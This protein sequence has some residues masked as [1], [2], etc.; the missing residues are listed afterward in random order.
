MVSV[1]KPSEVQE[2]QGVEHDS[3][4][5]SS[6]AET[7]GTNAKRSEQ[8]INLEQLVKALQGDVSIKLALIQEAGILHLP[9]LPQG[10]TL[11]YDEQ[12]GLATLSG[13]VA[14]VRLALSDISFL[15]HSVRP[16]ILKIHVEITDDIQSSQVNLALSFQHESN[17]YVPLHANQSSGQVV[18]SLEMPNPI[19]E[20]EAPIE[21]SREYEI[22]PDTE[23]ML[24]NMTQ[25]S[26]SIIVQASLSGDDMTPQSVGQDMETLPV[27][28]VPAPAPQEIEPEPAIQI[29]QQESAPEVNEPLIIEDKPIISSGGGSA[30]PSLTISGLPAGGETFTEDMTLDLEDIFAEYSAAT[31]TVTLTLSDIAAGAL[32][33]NAVGGAVVA[34]D[35]LTGILTVAGDVDDVNDSLIDLQFIPTADYDKDFTIAIDL[36]DGDGETASDTI[37]MTAGTIDDGVTLDNP[38]ADQLAST[39]AAFSFT[40][41]ANTFGNPDT[42]DVITYSATQTDG[43]ALPAWLSFD[44]VTGE[45]SGTAAGGDIGTIS[46]RITADDGQGNTV[47]D[48]FDVVVSSSLMVTNATQNNTVTEEVVFDPA[49]ITVTTNESTTT[50]TLTLSAAAAGAFNVATS[51]AVTSTYNAG[52]GI[53]QA[54][55]AVADVNA[56]LAGLQFTPATD[57]DQNFT[58]AVSVDDGNNPLQA[59]T[60]TMNVTAVNDAPVLDSAETDKVTVATN[61]FNLDISGNFSDVDTGETLNYTATL[62]GG[63]ALPGWLTLNPTTGVFSG[64]PGVGDIAT[65]DIVVTVTDSGALTVTDQFIVDV[66]A[67]GLIIG[68]PNQDTITGTNGVNE[69]Y[70][71]GDDDTIYGKNGNDT[72]YGEDGNDW[73]DGGYHRDSIEGGTGNDTLLGSLVYSTTDQQDTLKGGDGDDYLDGGYHHDSLLGGAGDDTLF[74]GNNND[75]LRAGDGN[76]FLSGGLHTDYLYGETGTYNLMIAGGQR[77]VLYGGTGRDIFSY[78]DVSHSAGGARD[79]IYSFTQGVDKIDLSALGYTGIGDLTITQGGTTRITAADG[80]RIDVRSNIALN[81][82]DF[83]FSAAS[84]DIAAADQVIQSGNA[85]NLPLAANSFTSIDD[86]NLVYDIFAPNGDA[87]H[88]WINFDN[89]TGNLS[90]T[91]QSAQSGI[92]DVVLRATNASGVIAE[93]TFTITVA[94]NIITGTI[95]ADT[96]VGTASNDAIYGIGDNDS[97]TAGDG[98][99]I[100][101]TLAGNDTIDAGTGNDTIYSGDG[102]D[103]IIGGT[104]ADLIYAGAGDDTIVAGPDN[105]NNDRN[106][107]VYAGDGNDVIYGGRYHDTLYGENGDDLIYG[108]Y[109]NDRIYGGAGNDTLLGGFQNDYLYAGDGNDSLNGGEHNDR[110]YGG[111]GLNIHDGWSGTDYYYG[112]SGTDLY[113]FSALSHSTADR[114][115]NFQQG[116]DKIDVSALGFTG[117]GDLNITQ[118]GVTTI[119]DPNSTFKVNVYSNIALTAADFIFA[120]PAADGDIVDQAHIVNTLFNVTL[121][122]GHFTSID[123]GNL[124][125]N[126][127]LSNGS[128]L[129]AWLTFDQGTQTLSGTP[130]ANGFYDITIRGINGAGDVAED[131]FTLSIGENII[132][133]TAGTD[134]LVGTANADVIIALA[135]DD[136]ITGGAGADLIHGEAGNDTIKGENDRDTVYAGDGDDFIDGGFERDTVYGGDGNDTIYGSQTYSTSDREDYLYGEGGND[137]IDGGYHHDRIYGGSG[138]DTLFGN[139]NNDYLY[140]GDGTDILIGGSHND[141]LY[142]GAGF[143]LLDGGAHTDYYYSGAGT[144]IYIF[145]KLTDST[146]D[147][148]YNFQQG[149]DKIDLSKLGFTG[150]GDL[151][152][153]QGGTTTIVDPGSSFKINVMSNI[154]LVAND[155]IFSASAS[156]GDITLQSA[157][158][159]VAYNLA[160]GVGHFTS[161]DDGNLVYSATLANG[162]PI[163]AWLSVDSTTGTL[164]GTPTDS[165]TGVFDIVLR[166]TNGSAVVAEDTFEL[167]VASAVQDGT[168]GNDTLTGT[169]NDDALIG[170][171]GDDSLTGGAGDDIL[172]GENG[173][174]TLIGGDGEDTLNG[175]AG[176]DWLDGGNAKDTIHGGDGNDVIIG[177]LTNANTDRQ[178]KLYG[179]AGNDTID[180]GY[181][182]DTLYGGDGDDM[183]YGNRHNDSLYGGA[184]RDFIHGGNDVDRIYGQDGGDLIIGW[185][186]RDSIY[187]GDGDDIIM[188]TH[189]NYSAGGN[190]DRLYDFTQ[191]E[192]KIDV[193]MLGIDS[194]DHLTINTVGAVTSITEDKSNFRIDIESNIVLA[195]SDF[196]FS[197]DVGVADI[198]ADPFIAQTGVAFSQNLPVGAFA[199]IDDGNIRYFGFQHNGDA[200]PTWLHVDAATGEI[201]GTAPSAARVS[202]TIRAVNGSGDVAETTLGIGVSDGIVTGTGAGDTAVG[203][204]GVSDGFDGLAGND[205]YAGNSGNDA[206]SGGAGNDTLKGDNNDDFIDGGDGD[207]S[208]DGGFHRDLIFGGAGNDTLI[209]GSNTSNND[210]ED[211]IFGGDGND[212][213]HGG[214]Y[215]DALYGEAGSDTIIGGIHND[216]LWGGADADSL[217]G[218]QQNDVLYGESGDDTLI[219]GNNNDSLYG[220]AGNDTIDGSAH[221]DVLWG[222]TGND[223]FKFSALTHSGG[224]NIDRIMDFVR[225]SDDIDVSPL[226]F[227]GIGDL[228][229]TNN[230]TI[231]TVTNGAGFTF[232]LQGVYA[233]DATDFLF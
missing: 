103:S 107:T 182:H 116:T 191:G 141:R 176:D 33:T 7:G 140:A 213:I 136:S 94:D 199:S 4:P 151:T 68:T 138:D 162:N 229:I 9:E 110:T 101:T 224:G 27:E 44:T 221:R 20:E 98:N 201:S 82:N 26:E 95:A 102:D 13:E 209:G 137:Y 202:I 135:D 80:L 152:I 179:D 61:A 145:S 100:I 154:A 177:G 120:A 123:D 30:P 174:D 17:H 149:T 129:P 5:V 161:I 130:T 139:N 18:P 52:T 207:D 218:S 119:V 142:G 181:H 164:S 14:N 64:T 196:I 208:I 71:R 192:D 43:S 225:G 206:I 57:Y 127:T 124:F 108:E 39:G 159:G 171:D 112:G 212:Y 163:P 67:G 144:D 193:S 70:G 104:Q 158:V 77:D 73:I 76:N 204:A 111:A 47:S 87:L 31:L 157:Q 66:S 37:A 55:G 93:D 155:F 41:P 105:T 125:Y 168:A 89:A 233:L 166:A 54:S 232:E 19:T 215:H 16:D 78:R 60:L 227:A 38:L 156:D 50:V 128:A 219:G 223:I 24:G 75:R 2:T 91:P 97:I 216:T 83:I 34:F 51:N 197:G 195:A 65:L 62:N 200:L 1:D 132:T 59:G 56:L 53:W 49:D 122:A 214:R 86:G 187:G 131:Q 230:G 81:A 35:A 74:G 180:G 42:L 114:I 29:V 10:V 15:P 143:N 133:G 205:D 184:G 121:G 3:A 23:M 198:A 188:F 203:A 148:I 113:T 40:P 85:W 25:E 22:L 28:E 63:G 173:N 36:L 186:H 210:R 46:V 96:L 109:H 69:I 45:I 160:L 88:W 178:D 169:A 220:G 222:G 58:V 72:I 150:I 8:R 99:D 48:D 146:A 190:R 126:A 92:Y 6:R 118:G 117:I 226:G 134:T 175:G 217:D 165:G 189:R 185:H 21:L 32:T 115:Y 172:Y 183:V 12:T 167:L 231:T 153:T 106:D 84:A 147:R 228:T 170:Y 11:V 79:D 211:T 90:G 194:L